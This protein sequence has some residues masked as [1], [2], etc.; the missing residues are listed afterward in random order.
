[1]RPLTIAAAGIAVFMLAMALFVSGAAA[2]PA[3]TADH[4]MICHPQAHPSDWAQ[5]HGTE[6]D[7][8]Q[9]SEATCSDCH[10]AADCDSC[11]GSVPVVGGS[12][13]Q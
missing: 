13:E 12:P 9:V 6:L 5:T 2:A 11:H 10:S 1:M 7:D 3:A 4:C 8:S